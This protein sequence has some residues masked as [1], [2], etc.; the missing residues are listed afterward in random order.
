LQVNIKS[1][2]EA[3]DLL[4]VQPPPERDF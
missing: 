3:I 2:P 1:H 4:S